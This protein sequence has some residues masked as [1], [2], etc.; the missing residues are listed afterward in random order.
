VLQ[1]ALPVPANLPA[2]L[3]TVQDAAK[4]LNVS[5]SFIYRH[6][7]ELPAVR[8]GRLVHF[9]ADLLRSQ[10]S[11]NVSASGTEKPLGKEPLQPQRRYQSGS[12]TLRGKVWYGAFR[13]DVPNADGQLERKQ[14]KIRL[15]VKADLPT[16]TAAKR[17]L[18]KHMAVTKPSVEMTLIELVERWKAAVVPTL[19]TSTAN[20]YVRSLNSRILPTLGKT[21]I[22]KLGRYEIEVFLAARG[23]QYARN[24]LREL[25]SSLSRVLSWAVANNW[26]EK[27]PVQGVKLPHGTGRKITR[28]VLTAEQV[29]AIAERLKE[30]YATLI[31]FVAITGLR[32]GEAVG[33]QWDDF[34][35]EVLNVQRRIYEGREDTLK[36]ESS[37]RSLPI[38][39][40]LMARLNNL[41]RKGKWVFIS[42]NG[43]PVNSSNALRRYI[44]PLARELG[45]ILGGWHDLRHTLATDLIQ[46]GV[47][48]KAVS[49]ILGHAN[50][51]VTLNT[52]THPASESFKGP[53]NDRATQ[54]IM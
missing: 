18:Q 23:K 40:V 4:F 35:G 6:Q 32:I 26:I 31:L 9:D 22:N 24:T 47:S 39:P 51:G 5:E 34:K 37:K 27:N 8:L 46:S 44:Q 1:P 38:A 53:L 50:V 43:T 11:S 54:F 28:T 42:E 17:E 33:I 25:R 41:G 14:R 45:I 21:L 15:G 2:S 36:T 16:K 48:A 52:Y 7:R 20:F 13:Q 29:R 19:K 49:E 12:V 30:P 3:L 10:F